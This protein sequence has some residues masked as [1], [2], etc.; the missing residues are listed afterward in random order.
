MTGGSVLPL[1]YLASASIGSAL[2][3]SGVK[4]TTFAKWRGGERG[5]R[6]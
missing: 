3:A 1:L 2:L 4:G 6:L 5:V